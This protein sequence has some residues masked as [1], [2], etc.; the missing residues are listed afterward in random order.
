MIKAKISEEDM[1]F[2]VGKS[3]L[4]NVFHHKHLTAKQ[5]EKNK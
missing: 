4:D 1:E 2:T 3:F 5:K